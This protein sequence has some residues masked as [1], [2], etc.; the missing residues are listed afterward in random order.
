MADSITEMLVDAV[1]CRESSGFSLAVPTIKLEE[2][3]KFLNV[4]LLKPALRTTDVSVLD[5]A[6]PDD[7]KK[8]RDPPQLD[9]HVVDKCKL[10]NQEPYHPLCVS[11]MF[12]GEI[13][14]FQDLLGC[15]ERLQ[16][17][18]QLAYSG[19]YPRDWWSFWETV[20]PRQQFA[21]GNT[22]VST[23]FVDSRV[24]TLFV[25]SCVDNTAMDLEQL[26]TGPHTIY[27]R[28]FNVNVD[29]WAN[30][31]STVVERFDDCWFV[32]SIHSGFP[33]PSILLVC[34]GYQ[35]HIRAPKDVVLGYADILRKVA[36]RRQRNLARL[37]WLALYPH[38]SRSKFTEQSAY[39]DWAF[40]MGMFWNGWLA[41]HRK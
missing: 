19:P 17:P 8:S 11:H 37:D 39:H 10:Y 40:D 29:G 24:S 35:P 16:N 6:I 4:Q 7:T 14:R 20:L 2:D 38:T 32:S 25:D 36:V 30:V 22:S 27:I 5:L 21:D 3:L 33:E 23:V 15:V 1:F 18:R 34:R 26:A 28:R 31:L 13:F 12:F 41:T 9:R